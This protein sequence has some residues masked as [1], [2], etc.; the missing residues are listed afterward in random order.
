M[1][2][3][4]LR[5]IVAKIRSQSNISEDTKKPHPPDAQC[6]TRGLLGGRTDPDQLFT[7]FGRYGSRLSHVVFTSFLE[8]T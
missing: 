5:K 6:G 8:Q 7:G 3:L 1:S 2:P 4:D